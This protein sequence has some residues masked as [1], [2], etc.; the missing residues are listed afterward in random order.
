MHG[1]NPMHYEK[2]MHVCNHNIESK[3]WIIYNS[4]LNKI[5]EI[6]RKF[7][8]STLVATVVLNRGI[9]QD[10]DIESFFKKDIGKVHDPFLLKDMDKAVS[11]INTA[12]KKGEKI[13][14]YGDY[15]V[16]GVTS[17]SILVDYL[18]KC[19]AT[20]EYY[21]PDRIDEGYGVNRQALEMIYN[22]G[23]KL[24][25]TV[26]SGITAVDEVEYANA[27]GLD[28]IITDHHEC[29]EEIPKAYAVINPKQTECLYPYKELAGVGVTF[30]LI[31]ALAG[32]EKRFEVIEQYS[33]IVCLGTIAD[34]V[35]LLGE[36][37]LI[38]DYGLKLMERTDN[39]GLKALIRVAG[40]NSKKIGTGTV[41]FTIAPR[42]NA[43]GRIGSALRAVELFLTDDEKTANE[44]A[45]ELNEEN[46]SRQATEAKILDEAM[47]LI[48]SDFDF[49]KQKVMVLC[50]ENWHHGVIGIVASRITDKFYRPSILIALEGEE[51]K[52]SGRSVDGF[53]LFEALTECGH[54]LVKFG[55]HELAAGLTIKREEIPEF[56][57]NIDEYAK[58]RLCDDDLIPRIYIDSEIKVNHLNFSTIK[59]LETLEPFGMGNA[60]PVFALRNVTI[61]DIRSVGEGK[62]LKMRIEKDG[63]YVDAIG[64]NMGEYENKFIAGDHVD[65][66]C[67]LSINSYR[68]QDSIQL[69]LKDMKMPELKKIEYNYYKTFDVSARN[70]IICSGMNN[71]RNRIQSNLHMWDVFS[72]V[73]NHK[74][75]LLI[76]NTAE[77]TKRLIGELHAGGWSVEKQ[78]DEKKYK[79]HYNV[80]KKP[81]GMDILINPLLEQPVDQQYDL[82]YVVDPCFHV[83][84][85]Q[86]I[87]NQYSQAY[88]IISRD[89]LQWCEQ[90]ME[91]IIPDRQDFVAIYQYIKAR[92]TNGTYCDDMFLLTRRIATSYGIPMNYKKMKSCMEIFGDLGLLTFRIDGD[93]IRII[94]HEQNGKK[95]NIES[96]ARLAELRQLKDKFQETIRFLDI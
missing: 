4:D 38:V 35:P 29:K 5:N 80:L 85:Y 3:K 16:D 66:A 94:L 86:R 18:R 54:H 93:Q 34:V 68:G 20:V 46:R 91:F 65:I 57:K 63:T 71:L 25:I 9:D 32:K 62:H 24:V 51:G 8:I 26:D 67:T 15:D 22:N 17:T 56:S 59:Q 82:V 27:L 60:G 88:F 39:L 92:S 43:A 44:I 19:H 2:K 48:K 70:D 7:N 72:A 87:L 37:R 11:R 49:N 52:G 55:G 13:T 79:I 53:N 83:A 75:V 12:L 61:S 21:I 42:V 28:M 1:N 31:Q 58:S 96:S 76:A 64:F 45:R 77:G 23:T 95:V 6:S 90:T 84:T 33:D 73:D 50:G 30:K 40:L 14:V 89:R 36:N 47:N 78:I 41:G 81:W 10:E 74:K 69:I